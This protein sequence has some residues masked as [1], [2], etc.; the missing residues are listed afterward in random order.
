[1]NIVFASGT[2]LGA[3]VGGVIA[4]VFGWRW[5]FG[6]Q[7]PLI[8]ISILVLTFRFHLPEREASKETMRQKLRRVDF[9]G[10]ATLVYFS[11][12]L[13]NLDCLRDDV[14]FWV[15]YW[16]ERS[17]MESSG[18]PHHSA[19]IRSILDHISGCRKVR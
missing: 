15:E 9:A 18:G 4:D 7:I 10:A 11:I 19:G 8:V 1:M 6:V 17:T 14:H 12:L 13:P 16:R 5:S 2:S 3:P